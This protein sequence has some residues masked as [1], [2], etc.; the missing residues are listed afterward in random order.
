MELLKVFADATVEPQKCVVL[1]HLVF[2]VPYPF[3]LTP[4]PEVVYGKSCHFAWPL[5]KSNQLFD[6]F[7]IRK[8]KRD[9]REHWLDFCFE[10][11]V[12]HRGDHSSPRCRHT[13]F[14]A[15]FLCLS[16]LVGECHV[17]FKRVFLVKVTISNSPGSRRTSKSSMEAWSYP[18]QFIRSFGPSRTRLMLTTLSR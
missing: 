9:F 14:S 12:G 7:Q 2:L 6:E 16:L 13:V 10:V 8:S 11:S 1:S 5:R 4:L 3:V 15:V 18:A 17:E